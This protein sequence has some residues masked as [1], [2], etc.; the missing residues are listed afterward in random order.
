[1]LDT[2]GL[3]RG[4][5][6]TGSSVHNQRIE[7][8]WRD[9]RRVVVRP[10]SNIFYHLEDCQVLDPLSETDLYALHYVYIK[11]IN[12]ALEEFVLQYNNHPMR[13]AHNHSPLQVFYEGVLSHSTCTG[14]HSIIAGDIPDSTYGIDDEVP[15]SIDSEDD[16]VVVVPPSVNISPE[17]L[18]QLEWA[19]DPIQDDNQHGMAL[20]IAAREFL[21][22][23]GIE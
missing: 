4:S 23:R 8:L 20:Y 7:R 18:E 3:N 16:S 11:R 15:G 2:R 5:I 6:I 12:K 1:M 9:L 13:T 17:Q 21:H 22:S 14:A 10:F 19:I